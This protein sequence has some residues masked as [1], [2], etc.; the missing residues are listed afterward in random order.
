MGW[1]V[2]ATPKLLYPQKREPVPI[3][4]ENG[5]LQGQFGRVRKFR[6]TEFRPPDSQ[7]RIYS[8][9]RL[10]YLEQGKENKYYHHMYRD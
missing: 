7:A 10:G 5:W 1:V 9:Y 8:L 6:P 4:R 3:I 2:N